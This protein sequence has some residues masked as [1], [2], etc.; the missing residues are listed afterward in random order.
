[1]PSH[2]ARNARIAAIAA[3]ALLVTALSLSLSAPATADS[4]SISLGG[5][6]APVTGPFTVG[7]SGPEFPAQENEAA[8]EDFTGTIVN[9]TMSQGHAAGHGATV[10]DTRKA[11]SNPSFVTG[12]SGLDIYQQRYARGGNQFTL[13]PPDQALCVG[14]GHVVEAVNDVFNVYDAKTGLSQLPDNTATNI[15]AGFP[16]NVNHA[17]DLNSFYGYPPAVTRP[18]GP[19]GPEI[20]DP[21]CIYDAATQRF[22]LVVLTLDRVPSTGALTKTNHLDLAVSKTADPTGQW[23][24]YKIDVTNDGT[25]TGGANPGPYLGDYPHI[26]ADANGVYLTTNAYPWNTNGF[27][28]AQIYA[29]SKAQLAAGA[30][31]VTMQHIDTSGM[32][33]APSDAGSTQPGFTVWPAQSPGTSSFNLN[34]N[35][36]EYFM[37]SNA[38]DE[39]THPVAGTGGSYTSSQVVVWSMTNTASLNTGT[40]ALQLTNQLV[41]VGDYALPPK[42]Q[43]PGAGQAP[44]VDAPQGHCINDTT[45]STIAGVGCWRL[46]VGAP[47]HEVVSTPDSNDTRMQQVTYANGKL[48]GALD[49]AVTVGGAN[50]AGIAWY[51][52]KPGTTS[53]SPKVALQ[54]YTSA[55]GMDFTYPAIGVTPSG[56]GVMAFTATGD[57][58]FPSAGYA[59]I[60]AIAGVTSWNIAPGGQG[61]AVDDGFTGYHAQVDPVRTRWGDYGAAAVD[62]NTVWIAS[63]YIPSACDYT[64]WGGP[65]FT[66]GSGDN[67]LG[68][69]AGASHGAGKRTALANWGTQ[70]SSFVP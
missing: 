46:L 57:G 19:F 61:Q 38:A 14:G 30:S 28:G 53:F 54:G 22:F 5:T 58:V 1:M 10:P 16:R 13:E 41:S 7:V 33:A 45:T 68:T 8:P 21:T 66:G 49:T 37:S 56:R 60:D 29:L 36:T 25:N 63:E 48:W 50:R 67:L 59:A 64:A 70:I 3:P 52:L 17:V 62:G 2:R 69:C 23:N 15:V 20:T 24:I 39:A 55:V 40:A 11:K 43:Q 34:G 26:G 35:G 47:G 18:A 31:S 42:Q 6:A 32:V 27:A 12:F 51:I 4:S 44:G 65:F 9:R